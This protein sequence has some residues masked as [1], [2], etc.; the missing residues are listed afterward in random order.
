M[1]SLWPSSFLSRCGSGSPQLCPI[2]QYRVWTNGSTSSP[3]GK[4]GSNVL[5]N[6]LLYGAETI[7]SYSVD[8]VCLSFSAE[9]CGILQAFRWPRRH[10]QYWQ[11]FS[12]LL[13]DST[14]ILATLS[15]PSSFLRSHTLWHIWQQLSFLSFCSTTR[16]QWVPGHLFLPGNDTANELIRRGA[17]LQPSTVPSPLFSRIHF[18]LFADKRVLC[19]LRPLV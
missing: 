6:C 11:F 9:V 8:P 14:S 3:L 10:R 19:S 1:L 13:S 2:S 18:F 7:L 12:F 15:S 16:L 5:G 4:V 17:L